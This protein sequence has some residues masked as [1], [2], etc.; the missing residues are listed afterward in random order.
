MIISNHVSWN[1]KHI[2]A[3]G[4]DMQDFD[5]DPDA[6]QFF[7]F[8]S[9]FEFALKRGGFCKRVKRD[10][11]EADWDNFAN[12]L[13]VTFFNSMVE[14]AAVNVLL[15]EP[16]RDLKVGED[17]QPC[18]ANQP[19]PQNSL[20]LFRAIRRIRNNL[21][22]G[23]KPLFNERDRQLVAA[24]TFIL[25]RALEKCHQDTIREVS[26]VFYYA[27]MRPLA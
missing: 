16:P 2:S 18:F 19:P 1:L 27:Q 14:N 5:V 6:V 15:R 24:A 23:E 21:F 10:K 9:R 25:E 12:A 4:K 20:E 11:A 8:F 26:A 17:G 22:H 3:E 13:S 7:A